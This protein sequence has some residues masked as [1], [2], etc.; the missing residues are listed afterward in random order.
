EEVTDD[1]IDDPEHSAVWVQS[2]NKLHMARAILS[3]LV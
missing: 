2:E 3:L 1:V